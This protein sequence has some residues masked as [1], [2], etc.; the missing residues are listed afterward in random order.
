MSELSDDKLVLLRTIRGA[1]HL[2]QRSKLPSFA[3]AV[4]PFSDAD[5]AVLVD[6]EIA[7]LWRPRKSGKQLRVK[8]ELWA[9]AS[10]SVREAIGYQ[11]ERLAAYRRV[12]LSGI[13]ID[14]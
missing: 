9:G 8:V 4:E 5:A 7:G 14:D 2:Y 11:A 10:A 13:D 12:S 1:P 6:G 3:T